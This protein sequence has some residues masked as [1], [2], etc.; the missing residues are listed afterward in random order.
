LQFI[1]NSQQS[2]LGHEGDALVLPS[3]SGGLDNITSSL[4]DIATK[5]DRIP[6]DQIGHDLAGTMQSL[7]DAMRGPQLRQTMQD[8]AATMADI[9]QVAQKANA[10]LTPALR[11]LPQLS[12]DLQQTV[13]H[14]NALLGDNGYGGNSD[15]GRNLNRLLDQL[16]ETSRSIR[17]LADFLDRHPEALITGRSGKTGER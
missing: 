1:P 17:L 3:Q 14:A 4:S 9:R 15:F 8:L 12:Q 2:S 5:L 16:N 11:R 7:N 13:A 6:F 10:G